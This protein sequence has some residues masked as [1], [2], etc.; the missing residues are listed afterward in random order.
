MTRWPLFLALILVGCSKGPEADLPAIGEARSLAAEWVLVNEQAAAGKLTPTYVQT[1][2]GQVREQLN[3]TA[4]SLTDTDT[5]YAH[6]IAALL[7][8]PDD[9]APAELRERAAALKTI[10][11]SLESA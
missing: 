9:A 4:E 1:M 10:E 8:Q 7:Q 6:Q 3:S 5:A 11:D 2:H